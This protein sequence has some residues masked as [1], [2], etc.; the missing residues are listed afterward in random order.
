MK[1]LL[2]ILSFLY[3]SS[4]C[5][6]QSNEEGKPNQKTTYFGQQE[7]AW[8]EKLTEWDVIHYNDSAKWR[9]YCYYGDDTCLDS[10]KKQSLP[11]TPLGFLDLKLAWSDYRNDT[12]ALLYTFLYD[13]STEVRETKRR[14]EA[15]GVEFNVKADTV[16]GYEHGNGTFWERGPLVR[17]ENF[18]HPTLVRFVNQNTKRLHPWFRK[19]A[20]RRGLLTE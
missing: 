6:L 14:A 1:V 17:Y 8:M 7:K 12:L 3:L 2:P 15:F 5:N 9:L 4:S 11:P 13:D 18:T 16:I 19:E 20:I 10:Y